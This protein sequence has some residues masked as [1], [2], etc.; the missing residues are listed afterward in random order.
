MKMIYIKS[1]Q[2]FLVGIPARDLTESEVELYGGEDYLLSTG[3]YKK[4]EK[5]KSEDKTNVR[6]TK[7]K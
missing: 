7:T 6:K 3:L 1:S 4:P 5:I 2:A